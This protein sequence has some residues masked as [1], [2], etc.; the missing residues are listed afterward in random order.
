[1]ICPNC[2]QRVDPNVNNEFM[3]ML[4]TLP[5]YGLEVSKM[6]C[7]LIACRLWDQSAMKL[8]RYSIMPTKLRDAIYNILS[9]YG[10]GENL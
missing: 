8:N 3:D 4:D 1:M 2:K 5:N 7:V 6:A 9:E 10:M